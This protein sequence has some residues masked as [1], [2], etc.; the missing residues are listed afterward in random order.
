MPKKLPSYRH[1]TG[2]D[3]AIVTLTDALTKRRRDYWLGAYGSPE[4]R[5]LYHQVLAAWEACGRRLPPPLTPSRRRDE[6]QGPLVS[7]IL[8]GYWRWFNGHTSRPNEGKVRDAIRLL[9]RMFGSTPTSVFGPRKLRLL[10][11][12]MIQGDPNATPLRKPWSR[13]TPIAWLRWA[14]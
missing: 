7:E 12:A 13:R 6:E 11:Q 5:E 8:L 2:C 10:R 14:W 9:R 1:R 3:Q 4:S